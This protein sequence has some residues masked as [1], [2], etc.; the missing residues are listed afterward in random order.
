MKLVLTLLTIAFL[1]IS[2][3]QVTLEDDGL[4]FA[5]G[6]ALSSGTYALVY[7]KTKNK[8]KAFWY[9][10]GISTLA[11]F[12]KEF[13]DGNII[14]GKFDTSE[15]IATTAGGFVASYSFNIFTGKKKRKKKDE[16]LS[17]SNL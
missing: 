7:S 11:G 13:Y 15:F 1:N 10:L 17:V 9:S 8:K 16:K 3:A 5:V 6:A 14:S 12:S 2:S 4:H